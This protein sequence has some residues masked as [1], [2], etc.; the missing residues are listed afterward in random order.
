MEESRTQLKTYFEAADEP[1]QAQFANLIDS[2]YS[3]VSDFSILFGTISQSGTNAPG[4]T[5]F[6]NSLG[7]TPSFGY[8]STGSF[9]MTSAGNLDPAKVI[10]IIPTYGVGDSAV[11]VYSLVS[12]DS[13]EID[14]YNPLTTPS[15]GILNNFP[16]FILM[17]P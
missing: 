1:T 2:F 6:F 9:T 3:I 16:F 15:D 13:F 10:I 11:D 8:G 17:I 12:P 14:T 4:L 5:V 7:F